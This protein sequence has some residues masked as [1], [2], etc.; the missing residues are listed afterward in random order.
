VWEKKK[1]EGAKDSKI[2]EKM[3][4][5]HIFNI[6]LQYNAYL[7]KRA[8]RRARKRKKTTRRRG[9]KEKRQGRRRR[10]RRRRR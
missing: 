4:Y 8:Q 9:R 6:Y 7:K 2:E 3:K 5:L 1:K 10:R